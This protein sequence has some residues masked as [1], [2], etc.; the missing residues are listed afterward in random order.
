MVRT[1]M[2]ASTGTALARLV[3]DLL[4]DQH[5]AGHDQPARLFAALDQL[6]FDEQEIEPLFARF[7]LDG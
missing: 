7:A 2:A 3:A 5:I 4:V 1:R 6:A